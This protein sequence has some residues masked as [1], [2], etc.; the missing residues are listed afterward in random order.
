MRVAFILLLVMVASGQAVQVTNQASTQKERPFFDEHGMEIPLQLS[1]TKVTFP[2]GDR[3]AIPELDSKP[4][5][6]SIKL[7]ESVEIY[8]EDYFPNYNLNEDIYLSAFFEGTPQKAFLNSM[9]TTQGFKLK[10]AD[11]VVVYAEACCLAGAYLSSEGK[12]VAYSLQDAYR[13]GYYIDRI[14][15]DS[16][17]QKSVEGESSE[18]EHCEIG[19]D[20][21][22][23]PIDAAPSEHELNESGDDNR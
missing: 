3:E 20:K 16:F 23:V 9:I 1:L 7:N 21:K 17:E 2:E 10:E 6:K 15:R 19:F 12:S 5:N 22:G 14:K 8:F 4:T 13:L 18:E 11:K